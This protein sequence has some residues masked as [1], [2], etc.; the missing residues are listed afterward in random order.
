MKEEIFFEC[1]VIFILLFFC[2]I[3]G[4][5]LF[6]SKDSLI[7]LMF[8]LACSVLLQR[9]INKRNNNYSITI[10][11][12]VQVY[13]T[14][15]LLNINFSKLIIHASIFILALSYG[16]LKLYIFRRQND[17]ILPLIFILI[18][19]PLFIFLLPLYKV[20]YLFK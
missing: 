3:S 20:V 9:H 16:L 19:I 10:F 2:Y 15:I 6:I 8:F 18:M 5:N 13:C 11:G 4:N 1:L 17:Y 12:M 7:S 14:L